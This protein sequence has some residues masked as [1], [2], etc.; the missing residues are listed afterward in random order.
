MLNFKA[1]N[2]QEYNLNYRSNEDS[3]LL[4]AGQAYEQL[5]N[6]LL[7]VFPRYRSIPQLYLEVNQLY[8]YAEH[9]LR[10]APWPKIERNGFVAGPSS[11][12]L[13]KH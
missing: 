6:A 4:T 12:L 3:P 7:R 10:V 11:E 2:K 9:Y 13:L 1:V 8:R 5:G